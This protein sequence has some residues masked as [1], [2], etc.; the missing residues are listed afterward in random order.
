MPKARA[1]PRFAKLHDRI[2][3]KPHDVPRQR[4]LL[5]AQAKLEGIA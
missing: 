3:V 4:E 1:H 2:G 5:L